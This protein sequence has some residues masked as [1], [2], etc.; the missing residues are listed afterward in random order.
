MLILILYFLYKAKNYIW[1]PTI[2]ILIAYGWYKIEPLYW[3]VRVKIKGR[4]L[5]MHTFEHVEEGKIL[6][7]ECTEIKS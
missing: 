6:D 7:L 2:L 1:M 5:V 3:Y 4:L